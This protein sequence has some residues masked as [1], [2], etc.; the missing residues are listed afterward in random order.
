MSVLSLDRTHAAKRVSAAALRVLLVDDD[1]FQLD[2]VSEVLFSLG[3]RDITSLGSGERALQLLSD[4]QQPFDLLMLDLA[5]PG[6][7]GFPFLEAVAQTGF[8]GA[9]IFISGQSDEVLRAATLLAQ[10]RRMALLGSISKPAG[11][12]ALAAL[13]DHMG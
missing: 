9:T 3:L 11:R 10:L 8:G 6:A 2:Y 4:R 1:A 12:A 13:I 5:M 7:D